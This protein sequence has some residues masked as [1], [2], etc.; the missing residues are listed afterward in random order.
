[1]SAR[2]PFPIHQPYY[3]QHSSSSHQPRHPRRKENRSIRL[4]KAAPASKSSSRRVWSKDWSL[5]RLGARRDNRYNTSATMAT[6]GRTRGSYRRHRG[7]CKDPSGQTVTFEDTPCPK[8][9]S[10]THPGDNAMAGKLSQSSEDVP[11]T[12]VKKSKKTRL[13][14]PKIFTEG[15][16]FYHEN[17]GHIQTSESPNRTEDNLAKLAPLEH[18]HNWRKYRQRLQQEK[19]PSSLECEDHHT[20]HSHCAECRKMMSTHSSPKSDSSIGILK[21]VQKSTREARIST[22]GANSRTG[23]VSPSPKSAS[24]S[25]AS[26]SSKDRTRRHDDRKIWRLKGGQSD[27]SNLHP[28]TPSKSSDRSSTEPDS[29]VSSQQSVSPISGPGSSNTEW[30][31]QF[32]VH[33]PSAREPNPPMMTAQQILN[34]QQSIEKVY[35]D[36]DA[37]VDPDTLPSPRTVTPES[38]PLLGRTKEKQL[39]KQSPHSSPKRSTP[40]FEAD[41]QPFVSPSKYPRP[42]YSTDA[43]GKTGSRLRTGG[44]G[45][46]SPVR[47]IINRVNKDGSFLG[48]RAVNEP[49]MKNPDEILL[50]PNMSDSVY[51]RTTKSRSTVKEFQPKPRINVPFELPTTEAGKAVQDEWKPISQNLKLAQCSKPS[52]KTMSPPKKAEEDETQNKGTGKSSHKENSNPNV[53]LTQSQERGQKATARDRDDVFITTPITMHT[54]VPVD[55]TTDTQKSGKRLDVKLPPTQT[56]RKTAGR[57]R[58][59]LPRISTQFGSKAPMPTSSAKSEQVS[60]G[61]CQEN[62]PMTTTPARVVPHEVDQVSPETANTTRGSIHM[63]GEVTRSDAKKVVDKTGLRGRTTSVACQGLQ[64]PKVRASRV[65]DH[66]TGPELNQGYRYQR[67][68]ARVVEVAELDGHQ[69]DLGNDGSFYCNIP[70]ISLGRS[71]DDRRENCQNA[72]NIQTI[73]LFF[74]IFL[75]SAAQLQGFFNRFPGNGCGVF[76]LSRVLHMA[77]HCLYVLKRVLAVIAIYRSTGSWPQPR[78]EELSQFAK[79]IGQALLYLVVLGFSMVVVGR[80]AGY[81][82]L[83]SSWIVWFAK[84]FGWTFGKIGQT[85]LS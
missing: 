38:K 60:G 83:V 12:I 54:S 28:R 29:S 72:V 18:E 47:P 50:F 81:V 46:N 57:A 15:G 71:G 74:D 24:V 6:E 7:L 73:S 65:S 49:D 33:M 2:I 16:R 82:V 84:P 31:D 51:Q 64:K 68:T 85:L 13:P 4:S 61:S 23:T 34:F 42:Y 3:A 37:M 14:V 32:V 75:L 1:M 39:P 80:A 43:L 9:P 52:L 45:S 41:A 40:I 44:D 20:K 79:E 78:E 11:D 55:M 48:C 59:N 70:S 22:R 36:G 5:I 26:S 53:N 35:K 77:E 67:E 21:P 10:D 76:I 56:M 8:P 63:P 30:E 19:S 25:P 58:E 17:T 27:S 66:G 62:A 69:I